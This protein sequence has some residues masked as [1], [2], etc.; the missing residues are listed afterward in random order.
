MRKTTR[1]KTPGMTK[2]E[3]QASILEVS[4][5]ENVNLN[6]EIKNTK[7]GI[8]LVKNYENLLKGANKENKASC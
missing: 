8:S 7:K 6:E 5:A 2:R 3:L 4:D 1:K